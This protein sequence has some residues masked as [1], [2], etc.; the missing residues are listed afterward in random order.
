MFRHIKYEYLLALLEIIYA[1]EMLIQYNTRN[2]SHQMTKQ[3]NLDIY[4]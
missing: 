4:Q 1:H 2:Y 3:I